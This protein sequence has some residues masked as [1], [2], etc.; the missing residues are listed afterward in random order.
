M[1][2]SEAG[3]QPM[4]SP[5]GRF[6]LVFNGEIYNFQGLMRELTTAG[7]VFRT[8]SDTEVIVHAWEEWGEKCVERLAGMFAFALWDAHRRT[9]FLARDR[10]G[11]KPLHYAELPGGTVLFASEI[12]GLLEHP[13]LPRALDPLAVEDFFGLGYIP[14]P[15]TIYRS[16]RRLPPG[17]TLTIAPGGDALEPRPYW[18]IAFAPRHDLGEEEAAAELIEKLRAAVDSHR[19]SEVPLGAFLSGG[20]DSSAMVALMA[21]MSADPVDAC[22]IGFDRPDYD[23]L[24]YARAVAG[25]FG[26]RHH[27]ERV[28]T[29]DFSLVDRLMGLYDEP[30][31]DSSA[32][33]TY[34]LCALARRHVTVALSGD[35]GD[36]LLAGYRRYRLHVNEER[37]RRHLGP[38]I[39]RP[40]FGLL[41]AVYPKL[42]WAPQPLRAKRTLQGLAS[43]TAE[44]YLNIVALL[45]DDLR[46]ALYTPAFR[47]ELQG[48]HA[49]ETFRRHLERAP[50]DDPLAQ[51]QYLDLKTYLPADILTKVDRA[52][53]AH[54]LEVRVPL[55]D[56]TFVEWAA[57][58]PAALK[59]RGTEGKALFKKALEPLLP[60][61]ILYR[62]KVG[63]SVPIGEW[64]RGPLR[65][66]LYRAVSAPAL[67]DSGFLEERALRRLADEHVSGVRNHASALWAIVMFEAFLR[68]APV[69]MA[70]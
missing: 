53:M 28:D 34:R 1:D 59:L 35:G 12:K 19:V 2:L 48:Y 50:T 67:M 44:G 9:L 58:L 26:A 46:A 49:V 62:P 6:V 54:S 25:R 38:A 21:G 41:G 5:N 56:H 15:R 30:F 45:R 29:G 52:S 57:T 24:E 61:D 66:R 55:L 8:R 51:V 17:H 20:V 22:S 43:D 4:T 33:P 32:L 40:L 39:R 64:F 18:D 16:V 47:R 14:D 13:R 7:H 3:R 65:D 60:A 23:E 63:F 70:A 69:A 37:V 42:A 27:A 68:R 36:E 10:L 11:I 31:A